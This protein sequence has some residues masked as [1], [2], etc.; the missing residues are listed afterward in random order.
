VLPEGWS[1]DARE[2]KLSGDPTVRNLDQRL[3]M[4]EEPKLARN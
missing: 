1:R 4:K 3:K 2:K